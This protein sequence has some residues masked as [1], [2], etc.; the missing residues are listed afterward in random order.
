M[1]HGAGQIA[2][3]R[4]AW[5]SVCGVVRSYITVKVMEGAWGRVCSMV[6]AMQPGEG[7]SAR[8]GKGL[9]V[10]GTHVGNPLAICVHLG[11]GMP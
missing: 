8:L 4:G 6:E 10:W 2:L 7:Y 3:I 9:N 11:K 1:Q 5:G